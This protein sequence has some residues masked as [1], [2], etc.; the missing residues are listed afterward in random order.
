[1]PTFDELKEKIRNYLVS[2]YED[3]RKAYRVLGELRRDCSDYQELFQH[4]MDQVHFENYNSFTEQIGDVR[5]DFPEEFAT[6]ASGLNATFFLQPNP[7]NADP[8]ALSIKIEDLYV[9]DALVAVQRWFG[10]KRFLFPTLGASFKRGEIDWIMVLKNV[11]VM[12]RIELDVQDGGRL[13]LDQRC[14][15]SYRTHKFFS[16]HNTPYSSIFYLMTI[17]SQTD[18]GV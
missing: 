4:P 6:L 3:L 13:D 9:V 1:M 18:S 14:M 7:T 12:D 17:M 11:M 5:V 16:S 2:S 15:A 10:G 8:G